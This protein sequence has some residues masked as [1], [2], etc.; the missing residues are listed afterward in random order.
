[1]EN[2]PKIRQRK[3]GKVLMQYKFNI[4]TINKMTNQMKIARF[5][6]KL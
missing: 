2:V 4:K 5:L 3:I 1:M 6:A